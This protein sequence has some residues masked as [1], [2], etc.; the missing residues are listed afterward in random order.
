MAAACLVTAVL[1]GCSSTIDG[2]ATCPGCGNGSEPDFSTPRPTTT[3]PPTTESSAPETTNPERPAGGQTL[4]PNAN[5]YVYI[6][7]RSGKTRCQ[8]SADNVGCESEFTESPIVDGTHANGVEVSAS[9]AN[10]WVLGNLGAMPT[11]TIGYDT[12]HAVGWTITADGSGTT[13]TNDGSGHG[14][15]VSTE[16]VDFF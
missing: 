13:F 3:S 12:Y 11:T 8:I 4:E 5:G 16:R 2:A 14:M 10:R 1:A 6:E 9:G 15:F 7:T